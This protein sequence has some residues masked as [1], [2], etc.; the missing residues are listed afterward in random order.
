M[1]GRYEREGERKGQKSLYAPST[2]T[3]PG[4]ICLLRE[5]IPYAAGWP[6][7]SHVPKNSE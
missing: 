3:G 1:V 6:W 4:L 2:C 5:M 7:A